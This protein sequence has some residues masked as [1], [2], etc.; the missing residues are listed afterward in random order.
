MSDCLDDDA[1]PSAKLVVKVL[2]YSDDPLTQQQISDRTR[3]SPRTVRSS[4]KRLKDQS[5][6]DER[7]YIPDARKQ[8]Y[9]LTDSVQE[10]LQA[11]E[12]GAES[13]EAV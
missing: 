2:E 13:A 8:L 5:V 3:L 7:V 1:P 9:A 12:S 10:C 11:G 6:I 4:I